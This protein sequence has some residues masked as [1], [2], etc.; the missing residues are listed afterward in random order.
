M[1]TFAYDRPSILLNGTGDVT[2]FNNQT[3]NT[4]NIPSPYSIKFDPPPSEGLGRAKRYLLRLINTSFASTFIFSIDNHT[5]EVVGADFVP[6]QSYTTDKVLV[7]IGQRYHV[8]VTAIDQKNNPENYWIRTWITCQEYTPGTLHYEQTGIVYYGD[9]PGTPGTSPWPD[10]NSTLCA[11]EPYESL[12]PVVPKD[13]CPPGG[14]KDICPPSHAENLTL[15]FKLDPDVFPL[16]QFSL[17]GP[18]FNPLR[19]DYGDPTFLN[20]NFTGKWPPSQ[21]MYP[22]NYTD[23]TYVSAML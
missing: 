19:V 4:T 15:Q 5:L 10:I 22:E 17:A 7:G 13:V 18:E 16:A 6:I 1:S 9:T 8:I 21:V 12:V 14:I 11:D 23:S 2:H 3:V 20:L